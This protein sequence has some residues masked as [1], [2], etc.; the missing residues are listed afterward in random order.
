ML[1]ANKDKL[2]EKEEIRIRINQPMILWDGRKEYFLDKLSGRL[3][4][5]AEGSYYIKESDISSVSFN[6][7][8]FAS[9]EKKS[10]RYGKCFSMIGEKGGM[11]PRSMDA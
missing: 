5:E 10:G 1:L 4:V 2:K 7:S 11:V 9:S 3:S 6:L 8:L